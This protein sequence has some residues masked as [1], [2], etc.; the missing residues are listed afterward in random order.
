MSGVVA[1]IWR[2][3][4]KGHGREELDCV[5]LTRGQCVPWDRRWAVL[6][7]AARFDDSNPKWIPCTNFSRISKAPLL[8]AVT[9]RSN[10]DRHEVT[11]SHPRLDDLTIDPDDEQDARA[12]IAWV[13]PIS[14]SDRALPER[15]VQVPYRGMTDTDYPSISLINLASHSEVSRKTGRGISHLRWRGNV[16]LDG[17]EPWEET[18]WPGQRL[19]AGQV[20]LEVVEPIVRCLA[21]A[22]STRT[23]IRDAD[24]LGTLRSGWAHQNMGVYARVTKTGELRRGDRVG[25]I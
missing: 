15:L 22:A 10:V 24:L 3:P 14:P 5:Q 12:F 13:L 9:A 11:L 21:T 23:G 25:I 6:H 20:E 18:G 2:H 1:Q 7:E 8:Q 19:R 4:I 17:L 16:V